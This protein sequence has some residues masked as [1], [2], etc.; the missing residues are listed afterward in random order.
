M[1]IDG[2]EVYRRDVGK[3]AAHTRFKFTGGKKYPFALKPRW[4]C[5][6]KSHRVRKK[7]VFAPFYAFYTE[8]LFCQY[9]V[10]D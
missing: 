2:G 9:L 3:E 5:L 1:E 10:R 6:S 7:A 8:S 4:I